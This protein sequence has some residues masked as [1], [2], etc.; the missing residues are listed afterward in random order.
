MSTATFS[1]EAPK[2]GHGSLRKE[3]FSRKLVL[4]DPASSHLASCQPVEERFCVG[5]ELH[6][7]ASKIIFALCLAPE[8]LG[9]GPGELVLFLVI[10]RWYT[11]Y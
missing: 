2:E 5:T 9:E 10:V 6:C 3:N 11:T 1:L 7:L 4:Q 8:M